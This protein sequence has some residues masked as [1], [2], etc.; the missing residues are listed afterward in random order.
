MSCKPGRELSKSVDYPGEGQQSGVAGHEK[1]KDKVAVQ[2][3]D[4]GARVNPSLGRGQAFGEGNGRRRSQQK[5]QD[6]TV[7]AYSTG[8]ARVGSK[9]EVK[10]VRTAE[11]TSHPVLRTRSTRRQLMMAEKTMLE[12]RYKQTNAMITR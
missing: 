5:E 12:Y 7:E 1:N 2:S 10:Q 9:I 8:S 11:L 3:S 4:K 6:V